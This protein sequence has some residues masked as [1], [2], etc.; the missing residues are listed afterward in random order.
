[1][2]S[3]FRGSAAVI[4]AAFSA[5]CVTFL[6]SYDETIFEH[7]EAVN[8][9][10]DKINVA[11]S[12]VYTSPPAFAMVQVYYV[13]ALANVTAAI[14]VSRGR[15]QYLR[16]R[17]SGR[18]AQIITRALENC[19]NALNSQMTAHRKSNLNRETLA[20]FATKD[21]CDIAKIMEG[22]LGG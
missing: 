7:L 3:T 14:D 1:M 19:E 15:E 17:A 18:P 16:V 10:I 4:L 22:R 12:K 2:R 6:P 20:V 21:A 13:D 8:D 11:V 9:S 5:A